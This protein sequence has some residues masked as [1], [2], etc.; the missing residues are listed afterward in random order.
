MAKKIIIVEDEDTLC[1]SLK[2]VFIRNGYDVDISGSAESAI[3]LLKTKTYDVIIT[4]IVLPGI[5][6]IDLLKEYK[7]QKP[8][9]IVIIM[10]A[11]ANLETAIEALRA[12]AY[13][14]LTKPF[15]H[16]EIL[17]VVRNAI[18]GVPPRG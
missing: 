8:E 1:E 17:G 10:T 3:E 5:S 12:G 2:R 4:D 13:D 11:Y 7:K 15:T 9:Q 14:Y 18:L 16:E 6:G